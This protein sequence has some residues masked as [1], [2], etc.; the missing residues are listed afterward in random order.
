[1]GIAEIRSRILRVITPVLRAASIGAGLISFAG[2]VSAS[3][4]SSTL[5]S[6]PT[7]TTVAGLPAGGS[8]TAV[9]AAHYTAYGDGCP[10][11]QATLGTVQSSIVDSSG[12]IYI[13]DSTDKELRVIYKSGAALSA[14]IIAA[15]AAYSVTTVQPGYIYLLVGSGTATG[16]G[17]NGAV[18][19]SV[20]VSAAVGLA[21][22]SDGNVFFG[23]NVRLRSF[24]VS[25]ASGKYTK[26]LNAVWANPT[27][28]ITPKPG[29]SYAI[30][31]PSTGGYSGDGL[32]PGV[33][34]SVA[35][36]NSPRGI[37]IDAN[38]NIYIA[39]SANNAIRLI[40]ASTGLLSTYIGSAGC[41]E[42]TKASC[43]AGDVGNSGPISGAEMNL[44]YALAFDSNGNLYIGEEE[45]GEVRAVYNGSGTLPGITNPQVGYIYL[46]AGGGTISTSG[47]TALSAKFT[48]PSGATTNYA[49]FGLGFDQAGNLYVAD[50]TGRIWEI[51]AAT[52]IATVIAGGPLT[53]TGGQT[54]TS[55]GVACSS[56]NANGSKT[57][58]KLGDGCPAVQGVLGLLGQNLTFDSQGN[59][60]VT[61]GTYGVLHE[62][63]FHPV[64]SQVATGSVSA[65][66]T[67]MFSSLTSQTLGATSEGAEGV[68]TTDFQTATGGTCT[69]GASLVVGATCS[70]NLEFSPTIPGV[71]RGFVR[72]ENAAGS[73]I[74]Q[75]V[76]SGTATGAELVVD[77][78]TESNLGTSLSAGG[79][80]ADPAGNV[81]VSDTASAS[82]IEYVGGSSTATTLSTGLSSPSEVAIDNLGNVFVAD[83]GNNRIAEYSKAANTTAYFTGS[84]SAPK[85]VAVDSQGHVYVAD[86]GN[87]R[88]VQISSVG[89]IRTLTTS[90]SSPTRL[91]FDAADNLYILDSG[92]NRVVEI[93]STS[94]TQTTVTTTGYTPADMALDA[95]GNLYVLDSAGLQAGVVTPS[96][97]AYSVTTGLTA[98]SALA[99]DSRANLYVADMGAGNVKVYNRQ[100][101]AVAFG[102]LDV[103]TTPGTANVELMNAGTATINFSGTPIDT[104]TG[105]SA[106]TVGTGS[107]SSGCLLSVSSL[108]AATY[109][110]LLA[111]FTPVATTSY[112]AQLVFPSDAGTN[113]AATVNLTGS[114][115]VLNQTSTTITLVS[116]TSNP[117]AYTGTTP[118]AVSITVAPVTGSGTPTGTVAVSLNGGTPATVAI[119]GGVAAYS[120]PQ[121]AGSDTISAVYS[122]DSQYATSNGSLSL[123]ITPAA[124]TTTLSVATDLTA[125]TPTVTLSSQVSSAVAGVTGSVNFL[126]GTTTL[127]TVTINAQGAAV[128]TLSGQGIPSATLSAEFVPDTT[129]FSS[130]TS[131]TVT[132]PGDFIFTAT[133]TS[134]SVTE[135]NSG[136]S[137]L[138]ITPYFGTTSVALSCSGLPAN[139]ACQFSSGSSLTL[140]GVAQTVTLTVTTISSAA[141]LHKDP[142]TRRT[143]EGIAFAALMAC[144]FFRRRSTLRRIAMAVACIG[145]LVCLTGCNGSGPT[146]VTP[147]GTYSFSLIAKSSG[148]TT[149]TIPMSLKI[150]SN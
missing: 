138:V 123:T 54:A 66:Q 76:V 83:T 109:C 130:S 82:L 98:P 140:S 87:N 74:S 141:S 145:V 63:S 96:G 91:S 23:D 124:T 122:S 28:A 101:A 86:T 17:V 88:I 73:V 21:L 27:T 24:F 149:H 77:P 115:V 6:I 102:L 148:G 10:A 105:S 111:T 15:N 12:N 60:Y 51:D 85:G 139:S 65:V 47:T 39:D 72:T 131:A 69:S 58:D 113:G 50:R 52:Q 150:S 71:I 129:N 132:E 99:L 68:T 5:L 46:I 117:S 2:L 118:I 94:G 143:P 108:P 84:F 137:S 19:D 11:S 144:L 104:L 22:D 70:L 127:G 48:I 20:L 33:A 57:T 119:V 81:F 49:T 56:T 89:V 136:V 64:F 18:G 14:A 41:V 9:C 62:L 100:Q 4:Q 78:G 67:V 120:F 32:P 90:V 121:T 125:A 128:L 97:A 134:L 126:S 7:M 38:E 116:P 30:I 42:G 106:F 43:T 80:A 45:S 40:T 31:V 59:L 142:L 112:S 1:M 26:M 44:P 133:P 35:E 37:A 92:N 93:P 95:A 36:T 8:V 107:S 61:D 53:S 16:N 110:S 147:N 13:A 114:G 29:Y 34:A 135:A 79:V 146:M 103:G 25:N 3:A 75:L 55:S